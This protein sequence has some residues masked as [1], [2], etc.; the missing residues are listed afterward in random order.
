[1]TGLIFIMLGFVLTAVDIQGIT[2]LQYPEYVTIHDNPQ[3]GEVI[4]EYV[5]GNM[6]GKE[7]RLD[8]MSDMLG[9]ILMAIGTTL[10]I[11]YNI[12]FVKVY[13]PLLLTAVLYVIV[14]ISPV[15]FDADKLVVYALGLS[16]LQLI[17]EIFME[18]T[19]IYT[20]AGTTSDLPNE[21]DTVLMKFGWIGSALCQA[22]LYF[23]VLV[24]LADWIIIVY[25]AAR[26]GFM[27]F[28]LDRM[29]RCRH[30]LNNKKYNSEDYIR[31]G[32]I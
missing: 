27:A 13:I 12:K 15:I 5:A 29:F 18:R 9:Y 7:L 28:C 4:Q 20:I 3:L 19:L 14:R 6:L 8:I 24:G 1:M 17:A 32:Q 30:Y 25:M 31:E 2:L 26:A 16:F 23:I 10:L 22:F 21:R 11:K